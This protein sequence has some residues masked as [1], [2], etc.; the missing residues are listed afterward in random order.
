VLGSLG[1]WSGMGVATGPGELAWRSQGAGLALGKLYSG[2]ATAG[3]KMAS[4]VT[5]S[6]TEA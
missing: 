6:T 4:P 1:V 3:T 5:A 2:W